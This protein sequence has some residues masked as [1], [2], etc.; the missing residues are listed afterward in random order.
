MRKIVNVTVGVRERLP[1]ELK[2]Y[3]SDPQWEEAFEAL[4]R[5][6]KQTIAVGALG[7]LAL[8]GGVTW[9]EPGA[10]KGRVCRDDGRGAAAR[11]NEPSAEPGARWAHRR[12]VRSAARSDQT[13][14]VG[15]LRTS[16]LESGSLYILYHRRPHRCAVARDWTHS[17]CVARTDEAED[18]GEYQKALSAFTTVIAVR[19]QIPRELRRFLNHM[20]LLASYFWEP[21]KSVLQWVAQIVAMFGEEYGKLSKGGRIRAALDTLW[22]TKPC[23]AKCER[24]GRRMPTCE[25][26]FP[27]ARRVW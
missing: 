25:S 27:A 13:T 9:A 5:G 2:R 10:A 17:Q 24:F 22:R 23:G 16:S 12:P 3:L 1:D 15:S 14:R 8:V 19:Y 4:K 20:R 6:L 7:V 18:S 26:L 21:E 11:G